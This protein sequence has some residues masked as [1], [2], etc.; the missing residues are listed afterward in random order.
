VCFLLRDR[1]GVDLDRSGRRYGEIGISRG[2]GNHNVNILCKK[3]IF[4]IKRKK[5]KE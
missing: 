2:W 3:N 5:I 1:K 4:E